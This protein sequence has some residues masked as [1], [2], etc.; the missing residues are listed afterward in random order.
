M[1]RTRNIFGLLSMMATAALIIGAS[2]S[3]T[4]GACAQEGGCPKCVYAACVVWWYSLTTS[5]SS[6]QS[7][8]V[9]QTD[10][11]LMYYSCVEYD[12]LEP[13]HCAGIPCVE[14]QTYEQFELFGVVV[15][16]EHLGLCTSCDCPDGVYNLSDTCEDPWVSS[17][18]GGGS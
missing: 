3:P 17:S 10:D 6:N 9:V 16:E 4:K 15:F 11:D 5:H 2:F 1:H 13:S 8:R 7:L 18:A 14:F 12:G